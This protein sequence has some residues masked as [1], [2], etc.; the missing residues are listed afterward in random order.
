MQQKIHFNAVIGGGV[1]RALVSSLGVLMALEE[2]QV[3][4]K[5][6]GGVSA[7]AIVPLLTRAG[8]SFDSVK[9]VILDEDFTQ[10]LKPNFKHFQTLRMV[11]AALLRRRYME[12]LPAEGLF[13]LDWLGELVDSMVFEW[14]PGF[15]TMAYERGAQIVFY[16]GGVLKRYPNGVTEVLSEIPA[17]VGLA[18]RA[19]CS[20][21]GFFDATVYIDQEGREHLLFD[22][23]LSWHGMCPTG[24]VEEFLQAPRHTIIA[25]DVGK[26]KRPNRLLNEGYAAVI[27]PDPPFQWYQLSLSRGQKTLG[28]EAGQKAADLVLATA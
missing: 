27:T 11:K 4:L 16:D 1:A 13:R 19:T 21:P 24:F 5:S 22:G 8:L 18:I 28:I 23:I 20:L 15:W 12:E 25:C 7:G 2:N 14:P 3:Q 10:L 6:L 26:Y 17:P 9:Q